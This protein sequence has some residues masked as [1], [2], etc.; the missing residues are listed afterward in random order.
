MPVQYR[1]HDTIPY[2]SHNLS[3]DWLPYGE[4]DSEAAEGESGWSVSHSNL[5]AIWYGG[6]S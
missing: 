3:A 2:Y 5:N 4:M 6:T 1:F